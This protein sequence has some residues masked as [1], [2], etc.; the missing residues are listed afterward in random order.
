MGKIVKFCSSCDEGFAEKFG[1]CPNCAAPLQAFEMNPLTQGLEPADA[2]AEPP[3]PVFLNE[4]D[5]VNPL[6]LADE[7]PVYDDGFVEPAAPLFAENADVIEDEIFEPAEEAPA[8]AAADPA[9][10]FTNEVP[11][12]D[13]KP[14]QS[15]DPPVYTRDADGDY[16]VTVIQEKTGQ[17]NLLLLGST[18]LVVTVAIGSTIVSLFQKDLGIGA[19]GSENS[20]AYLVEQVPVV[21]EDEPKPDKDK[22][23]GGGGGGR[24]EE[25]E[26]TQGDMAN[27]TKDPIRPPDAKVHR[28]D[29]PAL[30]MPPPSTKG[31]K[32][33]EQ[34]FDRYGNPDKFAGLAS[35]GMG[36]GG[37]IGSGNGTG[38]GSGNGSGAGSGSGSGYGSGVGTGNGSGTGPGGDGSPPPPKPVGVTTSFKIISKPRAT[39]TDDAR[40]NNVQGSVFVK[41]TLLASGQI[42]SVSVVKGLPHGLSE[43]AVAAARQIKFE[44]KKINGQPVTTIVTF[45]YGFNIY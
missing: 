1:F 33:F 30:L 44:P 7:T 13:Q 36:S 37:G 21:V 43:R 10:I 41:V 8:I 19:I 31:D 11:S 6:D 4:I 15:F 42:G 12:F 27:Q 32:K 38:Q 34:K 24:D 45:D 28:M 2:A 17:R 25:R 29:D 16:S 9:D 3:A 23:G 20:I 26:E 22:G 35:N 40:T 18:F 39:Y 14:S 5:E